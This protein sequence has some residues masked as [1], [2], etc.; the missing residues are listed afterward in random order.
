MDRPDVAAGAPD[1]SACIRARKEIGVYVLQQSR[2]MAQAVSRWLPTAAARVPARIMSCGICG[3]QSVTGAGFLRVLRFPLPILIPPTAP[4][5]SSSITRDRYNRPIV[6]TVPSAL[7]LTPIII[8]IIRT[9]ALS[10]TC[11][12]C[13]TI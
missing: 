2:A 11:T 5:S 10:S 13:L 9:V 7:G 1:S 8:I 3:G 4:H 6:A 12:D